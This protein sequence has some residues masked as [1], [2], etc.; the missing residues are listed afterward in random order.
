MP[1]SAKVYAHPVAFHSPRFYLADSGELLKEPT[2]EREWITSANAELIETPGPTLIGE[3]LFLI[4]GEI[5]RKTDFEKALPGSLMEVD[6]KLVPD[7]IDDDQAVIVVLKNHGL[8]VLTGC[9]HAGVVNTVYYAQQLTGINR[10]Y[11]VIGGFHLSGEPFHHALEPTLDALR[12]FD[13]TVLVPMHCTGIEAKSLLYREMPD[14]IKVSGVGTTF[15][16]PLS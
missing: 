7:N 1:N 15:S 6:G 8:V 4:T 12:M 14:R 2:F 9:A 13:P 5:P 10:V 16:L 3:D 11:A